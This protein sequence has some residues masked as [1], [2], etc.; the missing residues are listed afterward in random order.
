MHNP[1][2]TFSSFYGYKGIT[3]LPRILRYLKAMFD[4]LFHRYRTSISRFEK[5]DAQ[6][7]IDHLS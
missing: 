7:V 4:E 1:F 3:N 5:N 2:Y 6:S